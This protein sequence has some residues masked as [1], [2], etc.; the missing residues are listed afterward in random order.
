MEQ[1]KKTFLS[2]ALLLMSTIMYAQSEIS[3]TVVD[4][5]GETVIGATVMEKGTTN[6]TVTDFDGNFRLKVEPGK[7]LVISYIGFET[8]E[9]AAADGMTVTMKDNAEVLAEVV[10]T[11]YQIQRKQ[12]LTGAVAVMD[13]K[14]PISESDPNMLNSMRWSLPLVA[15]ALSKITPASRLSIRRRR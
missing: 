12:D 4:P 11:G 1:L 5:T 2:L 14:G 10:V 8:V 7:T 3:G 13:M 15:T 6:G 9:M